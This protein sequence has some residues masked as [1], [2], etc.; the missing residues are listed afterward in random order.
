ME[1]NTQALKRNFFFRGFFK[2]RG[3]YELA[4]LSPDEYRRG[5]L[6]SDDWKALRIWLASGILFAP[7]ADGTE[8]LTPDG[9]GRADSAMAGFLRYAPDA[10]LVVE[11]YS[12]AGSTA[13]QYVRARARAQLV[14][15]YLQSRFGL[16][17]TRTAAMPLGSRASGSPE[18]D[19]WDGVALAVFVD[20]KALQSA[21]S[22]AASSVPARPQGTTGA[23][24]SRPA[25]PVQRPR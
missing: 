6:E 4:T 24:A 17:S 20:R 25:D 7:T 3:Y 5:A 21:P 14:L 1:E 2:D 9:R 15:D 16:T 13:E 11:G 23:A 8:E 12:T 18:G 22:A 19:T 10:P